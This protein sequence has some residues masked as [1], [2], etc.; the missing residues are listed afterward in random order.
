[1]R[2]R[3]AIFLSVTVPT[4]LEDRLRHELTAARV[5]VATHVDS[6]ADALTGCPGRDMRAYAI[7][8]RMA[9]RAISIVDS[10]TSTAPQLHVALFIRSMRAGRLARAADR[11]KDYGFRASN[12]DSSMPSLSR[13]PPQ[14]RR[15]TLALSTKGW[16][17]EPLARARLCAAALRVRVR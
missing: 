9:A 5:P 17:T 14:F 4:A 1:M 6:D 3:C 16:G 11:A 2:A 8:F 10:V 13:V 15:S 7:S 12:G